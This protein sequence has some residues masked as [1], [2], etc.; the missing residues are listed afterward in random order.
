MR[1]YYVSKLSAKQIDT[2]KQLKGLIVSKG[3]SNLIEVYLPIKR[4]K[5]FLIGGK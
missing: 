2:I 1:K 5:L 4:G 3:D